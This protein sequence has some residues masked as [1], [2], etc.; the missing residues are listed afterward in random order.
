MFIQILS[1]YIYISGLTVERWLPDWTSGLVT[2]RPTVS[3]STPIFR[4]M[5]DST[6]TVEG[7]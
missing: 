3:V 1:I 2:S 5:I 4:F 7:W 6:T